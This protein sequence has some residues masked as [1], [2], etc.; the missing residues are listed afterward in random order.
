ME[1]KNEK[2]KNGY[3]PDMTNYD[4]VWGSDQDEYVKDEQSA[5][6]APKQK[7]EQSEQ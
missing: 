5:V 1:K 2:A 4:F 6:E 3:Q 7:N